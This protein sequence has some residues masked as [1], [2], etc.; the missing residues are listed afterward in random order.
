GDLVDDAVIAG[1][2]RDPVV[3]GVTAT[4]HVEDA[5]G[6]GTQGIRA[7]MPRAAMQMYTGVARQRERPNRVEVCRFREVDVTWGDDDDR[8]ARSA[9]LLTLRTT[10]SPF[11]CLP[12]FVDWSLAPRLP[13]TG[14]SRCASHSV[15]SAAARAPPPIPTG[16]SRYASHAVGS[17]AAPSV[18]SAVA[19]LG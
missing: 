18:G 8:V 13:L 3:V 2:P 12:L 1:Q 4:L 17:A 10:P 9:S 5:Q 19:P 14:R 16:R 6:G 7:P 11:G 15:G